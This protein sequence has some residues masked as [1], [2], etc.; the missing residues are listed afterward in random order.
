MH[1]IPTTEKCGRN[2]SHMGRPTYIRAEEREGA[3]QGEEGAAQAPIEASD[4]SAAP[5]LPPAAPKEPDTRWMAE[6]GTVRL[7]DMPN[8]SVPV[9]WVW[10]VVTA[11]LGSGLY[12]IIYIF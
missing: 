1:P 11:L 5:A 3:P 10:G 7:V 9:F 8:R 2:V 12:Y 4:V 6:Y